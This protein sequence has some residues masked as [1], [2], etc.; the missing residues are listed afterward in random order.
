MNTRVDSRQ[1]PLLQRRTSL[2]SVLQP[3][4]DATLV[5]GLFFMVTDIQSGAVGM[6][7]VLFFVLLLGAMALV[8]DGFG[9]YR[10]N[11]RIVE[12]VADIAK[13]WTLSF[14]GVAL[15][16][17]LL[18]LLGSMNATTL[19]EIF[20]VGFLLQVASYSVFRK[21]QAYSG[22]K[23]AKAIVVVGA[24]AFTKTLAETLNSNPWSNERV[25]G[26]VL[27]DHSEINPSDVMAL[28]DQASQGE[29]LRGVYLVL[30]IERGEFAVEFYRTMVNK[31]IDV[32]WVPDT[33][34]LDLINPNIKEVGGNPVISFSETPLLGLQ[35]HK[36]AL[37]DRL[38]AS[39]AVLLLWPIMLVAAVAVK[40]SSPGPILFKQKRTGWDGQIFEIWKFRS[41]RMD[42]EVGDCVKQA[43][44]NDPRVTAVGRFI[45]RTSIDELPQIFN[46]LGGSMSLVGPR[47]H[48]IQHDRE[49]S[50]QIDS[51]LARHRIK[52]GITGLAQ[53]RGFRGETETVDLMAKRV[54]ADLEYINTWSVWADIQIIIAT[55]LTLFNKRA[56]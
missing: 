28:V 36:K 49:Y 54:A 26:T 4:V 48:A 11:R 29:R 45:R 19:F 23:R 21:L 33:S 12:K 32:H 37:L 31:H 6:S 7:C 46:V 30:P 41:M 22:G 52:P 43:T 50:T 20:S 10:R 56:Y 18:N 39:A 5:G 3:L 15:L 17:Y 47:P 8:Y 25:V 35:S 44:R 27:L 40:L 14:G 38:V 16:M 34:S 1:S 24:G 42:I 51:Y 55:A 9:I 13:A 53:V 2:S